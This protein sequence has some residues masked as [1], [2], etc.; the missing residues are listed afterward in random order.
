MYRNGCFLKNAVQLTIQNL[1]KRSYE[2]PH[3]WKIRPSSHTPAQHLWT[4]NETF[5]SEM[6]CSQPFSGFD[7][8]NPRERIHGEVPREK[9]ST[10]S[11]RCLLWLKTKHYCKPWAETPWNLNDCSL[12]TVFKAFYWKQSKFRAQHHERGR[13]KEPQESQKIGHKPT[14]LVPKKNTIIFTY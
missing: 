11:A 10:V 3:F 7:D 14:S 9:A 1:Y 6:C 8:M 2:S 5:S 12:P 13:I 4:E